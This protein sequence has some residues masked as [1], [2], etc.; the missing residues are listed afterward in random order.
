MKLVIYLPKGENLVKLS[1]LFSIDAI[2]CAIFGLAFVLVPET[3]MSFYDVT[4]SPGGALVARLF[5][6]VLLATAV[7]TWFVR[8]AGESEARKAI[9]LSRFVCETAGF[10]VALLGQL[11][12]AVNALGWSTVAIYLLFALGYGYFQFMKPSTL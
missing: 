8:N 9:I 1:T 5:G 2:V 12:G 3:A 6:K 10:I 7:L 11:A 4:L